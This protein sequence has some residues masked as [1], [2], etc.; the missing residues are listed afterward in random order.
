MGHNATM[1][2][3]EAPRRRRIPDRK[4]GGAAPLAVPAFTGRACQLAT[5]TRT[6]ADQP[7][8]VLVEGEAGIGKTRLVREC[9]SCTEREG[10]IALV[11]MCPPL[12]EPFPLGPIVEAVRRLRP[13]VETLGLTPLAG[14][15]RPLW[16]DWAD[17][18]PPTLERL[19]NRAATRHRQLAAVAELL[20]RLAVDLLVVEDAHWADSS[21]LDL[22]LL[23]LARPDPAASLLVTFRPEEVA[24]RSPLRRVTSRRPARMGY[25]RV[26]LEPLGDRKSVV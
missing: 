8:L 13:A 10:R 26:V 25:A 24:A 14:A 16:P 5:V 23:L 6:L 18:L 15:L 22:L 12:S 2:S 17:A 11:A 21:T 3:T 7:A 20:D 4:A 9:L 1:G 19:P